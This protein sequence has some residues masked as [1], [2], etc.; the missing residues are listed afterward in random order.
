MHRSKLRIARCRVLPVTQ[1][2]THS[3]IKVETNTQD[4]T[5]MPSKSKTRKRNTLTYE[6]I[7][8]TAEPTTDLIPTVRESNHYSLRNRARVSY[9][10]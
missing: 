8:P 6:T 4:H 2:T 5:T 7:E 3:V 9:P 1:T 10:K